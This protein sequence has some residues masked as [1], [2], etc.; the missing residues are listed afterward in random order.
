MQSQLEAFSYS[1]ET[2]PQVFNV[3]DFMDFLTGWLKGHIL[4]S[5]MAYIPYVQRSVDSV[6]S[7]PPNNLAS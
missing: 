1:Y 4:K 5:N 6:V 2:N 3:V 7:H